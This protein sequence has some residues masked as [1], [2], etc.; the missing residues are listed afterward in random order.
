[1][2]SFPTPVARFRKPAALL[3]AGALALSLSGAVGAATPPDGNLIKACVDKTTKVTRV[4]IYASPTWCKS[5][6]SYKFWSKTGPV[7]PK[8]ANGTNGTNGTNGANGVDG[9]DGDPSGTKG[10]Q[11][12]PGPHGRPGRPRAPTAPMA[13]TAP[14]ASR[15]SRSPG[16]MTASAG[17]WPSGSPR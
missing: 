12:L 9:T 1:M 13:R 6:E 14:T 3:I 7:G 11:G 2:A 10:D 8:G 16:P 15:R 4:T 5:T 17:P